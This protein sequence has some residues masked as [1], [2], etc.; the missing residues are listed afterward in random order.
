[1]KSAAGHYG[2]KAAELDFLLNYDLKLPQT[3]PKI[4][5][6]IRTGLSYISLRDKLTPD[7]YFQTADP[8]AA[9]LKRGG[10]SC[11]QEVP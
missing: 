10:R 11:F 5:A 9:P 3:M 6:C 4:H 1:M 2:L 8:V 7:W